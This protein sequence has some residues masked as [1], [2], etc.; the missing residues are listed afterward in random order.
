MRHWKRPYNRSQDGALYLLSLFL[1][2][3]TT[4]IPTLSYVT[5]SATKFCVDRPAIF[6]S[7]FSIA[8][9]PSISILILTLTPKL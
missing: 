5:A 9:P 1:D 4:D 8:S 7:A 3:A 2:F 6:E